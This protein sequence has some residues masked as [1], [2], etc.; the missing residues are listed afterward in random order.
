MNK[1]KLTTKLENVHNIFLPTILESLYLLKE[2]PIEECLLANKYE[3][4]TFYYSLK[5]TNSKK[6]INVEKLTNFS[7]LIKIKNDV[8]FIKDYILLPI[9]YNFKFYVLSHMTAYYYSIK[10]HLPKNKSIVVI[11]F[12]SDYDNEL[13]SLSEFLKEHNN[14][15]VKTLFIRVN[16]KNLI[17]VKGMDPLNMYVDLLQLSSSET[18]IT[19]FLCNSDDIL[20]EKNKLFNEYDCQFEISTL[21]ILIYIFEKIL[22]NLKIN[23]SLY[24]A[25]SMSIYKPTF[26]LLNYINEQFTNFHYYENILDVESFGFIKYESY[27]GIIHNTKNKLTPIIKEYLTHDKF[28]GQHNLITSENPIYCKNNTITYG[29]QGETPIIKSLFNT[30]IDMNFIIKFN[31]IH[32]KKNIEIKQMIKQIEHLRKLNKTKLDLHPFITHMVS[33]AIDFCTKYDIPINDKY[34]DFKPLNYKEFIHKYFKKIN[35]V[36]LDRIEIN[37]DSNYSITLPAVTE[38]IVKYI[39]KAMPSVECIIDGTSNIGSTAIVLS[40]HFKYIYSVEIERKTYDKLIH[41]IIEYRVKNVT[42]YYDDIMHFMKNKQLLEKIHFDIKTY[43]L[44]LDPPWSG[45]FYKT[46]SLIDLYLGGINIVTFLQEIKCK[47]ICLKV[48]FNY[49]FG[50]LYQNFYN[51]TIHRV[52]GFYFVILIL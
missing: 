24:Y 14:C 46:E 43:C 6:S 44:F 31:K 49:N 36:N 17:A 2:Y 23:G 5:L 1:L 25:Y 32:D 39:K 19:D 42:A 12:I 50:L 13:S 38:Q 7:E 27:K 20:V 15:K 3:L 21:P 29:R 48:P 22:V 51:I 45:V 41:N 47:Y 10:E 8:V 9:M 16:S 40:Q 18:Q 35:N 37:I 4:L 11:H 34:K 33:T 52:S 28:F 30:K 26:Q